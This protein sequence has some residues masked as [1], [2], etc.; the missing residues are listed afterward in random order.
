MTTAVVKDVV[1]CISILDGNIPWGHGVMDIIWGFGSQDPGSNPGALSN[2]MN[3]KNEQT[4]T[5][6]TKEKQEGGKENENE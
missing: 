5:N 4:K 6:Q 1:D 3:G 2:S